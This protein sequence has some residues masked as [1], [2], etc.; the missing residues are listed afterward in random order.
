MM[1]RFTRDDRKIRFIRDI[2][3]D[4]Y[5]IITEHAP[6]LGETWQ[7]SQQVEHFPLHLYA[8]HCELYEANGYQRLRLCELCKGQGWRWVPSNHG[9]DADR[10]LCPEC[11]GEGGTV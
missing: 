5:Y 3:G 10:D 6:Q 11:Q 1:T 9:E 8:L 7:D 2:M 4:G